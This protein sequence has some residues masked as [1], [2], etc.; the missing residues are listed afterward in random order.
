MSHE[1]RIKNIAKE[2]GAAL[3]GIASRTRLNT[4]PPSGDSEYLMP[5]TRSI[6]S[7]AIPFNK[8]DIRDYLGKRK[9]ISFLAEAKRL[10]QRLYYIGDKINDYLNQQGFMSR[11][12]DLNMVYRPEPGGT[13]AVNRIAYIPD[14]SHRYAAVAAGIGW[15]GWSGN[16]LTEKYGAAVM[17]GSVLT[18]AE[19]QPDPIISIHEDRCSNCRI[20]IS[21]CPSGY[22]H[23]KE[24]ISVKIGGI[25]QDYAKRGIPWRCG[26][27]C[28]GYHGLSHTGKWSTWSPYRLLQGIPEDDNELNKLSRRIRRFDPHKE[29]IRNYGQR[30][31]CSDPSIVYEYTCA[32]CQLIC[33]P[34]KED[35]NENLRLLLQSGVV[36]LTSDG[37]RMAVDPDDATYIETSY[38]IQVAILKGERSL[39]ET[40]KIHYK[41]NKDF[42]TRPFDEKVLAA[43]SK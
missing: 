14:F 1:N 38:G 26:I 36:V 2:S 29:H 28:N 6:I 4:A 24:S 7:Y 9:W 17:L 5:S 11:V 40:H 33:W 18:S 30:D 37:K 23:S 19:L 21:V 35:R 41:N 10:D 20:C 15:I 3:V 31:L 39:I 34:K 43:F 22:F 27:S 12:V 42:H 13:D 8:A 16:L 25:R 32:N